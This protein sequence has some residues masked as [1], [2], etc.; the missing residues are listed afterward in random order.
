MLIMELGGSSNF[1]QLL[2]ETLEQENT[3]TDKIDHANYEAPHLDIAEQNIARSSFEQQMH[4]ILSQNNTNLPLRPAQSQMQD[5]PIRKSFGVNMSSSS[6]AESQDPGNQRQQDKGNAKEDPRDA[7]KDDDLELEHYHDFLCKVSALGT[8]KCVAQS[9]IEKTR[10]SPYGA[11]GSMTVYPG[12]WSR[13]NDDESTT[14]EIVAIKYCNITPPQ[15]AS[16]LRDCRN[17]ISSRLKSVFHELKVMSS[18]GTRH[19]DI[20]PE[21]YAMSWES[22]R[23]PAGITIYQPI[24][25]VEPAIATLEEYICN[26]WP[27]SVVRH[28]AEKRFIVSLH[29]AMSYLH[30]QCGVVHGDLKPGNIL[31]FLNRYSGE[32]DAKL[33]DFGL[34]FPIHRSGLSKARMENLGPLGTLYWSAPEMCLEEMFIFRSTMTPYVADYYSFGLI[35]WFILLGYPVSESGKGVIK[36]DEDRFMA[37]KRNSGTKVQD[38]FEQAF[39]RRWRWKV[40]DSCVRFLKKEEDPGHRKLFMSVLIK[41]KQ[42]CINSQPSYYL[43]YWA[44]Y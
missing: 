22:C 33:S 39:S 18:R 4:R 42:V 6:A 28:E 13:K 7:T 36:G 17:Q 35:V 21:V 19:S 8:L 24:L 5:L 1:S 3:N 32:V 40:S 12:L 11:G 9:D 43:I 44:S 41:V 23:T 26:G 25:V 37:M 14:K 29:S 16:S 31:I 34:A 10:L 2:R 38:C 30:E 20:F 15:G 27:L